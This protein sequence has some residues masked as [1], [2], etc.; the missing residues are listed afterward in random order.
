[1]GSPFFHRK[2]NNPKFL[3]SICL[4]SCLG[5]VF[6]HMSRSFKSMKILPKLD[7]SVVPS[8]RNPVL[9]ENCTT[10]GRRGVTKTFST[11]G[12]TS[13]Q[14][15]TDSP[16]APCNLCHSSHHGL[17]LAEIF[18]RKS[19]FVLSPT[20]TSSVSKD[21]SIANSLNSGMWNH[22]CSF[23]QA[24]KLVVLIFHLCISI[25]HLSKPVKQKH[26][27]SKPQR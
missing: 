1:M 6:K 21:S 7:T 5:M 26:A 20:Q 11:R 13:F 23:N 15:C 16:T 4:C 2:T 27:I 17:Y 10:S 25:I 19:F 9:S 24:H 3:R 12:K 8:E 14:L 18:L 22:F